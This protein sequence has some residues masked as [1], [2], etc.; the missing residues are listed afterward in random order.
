ML[1]LVEK[2]CFDTMKNRSFKIVE[3][4]SNLSGI[5][6]SF[7]NQIEHFNNEHSRLNE[8]IKKNDEQIQKPIQLSTLTTDNDHLNDILHAAIHL[9]NDFNSLRDHLEKIERTINDFQQATGDTD[10]G[11]SKTIFEQLLQKFDVLSNDYADFLRRCKHV[12][13]QSERQ[14]TM[15]NEVSQ[16]HDQIDKTMKEFDENRNENEVRPG[17]KSNDLIIFLDKF[18]NYSLSF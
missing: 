15:Y 3:I 5:I 7:V 16:L 4:N 6:E 9:Q 11:K 17:N 2:N 8:W 10:G 13:D 12:C 1:L 18:I 14:L